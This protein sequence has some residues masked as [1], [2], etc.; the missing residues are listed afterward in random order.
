VSLVE[1]RR[2]GER[3]VEVMREH[4]VVPATAEGPHW[5]LYRTQLRA[6][7]RKNWLFAVRAKGTLV[8]ELGVPLLMLLALILLRNGVE[9]RLVPTV[10]H[11]PLV[12]LD[13]A[14]A[15][16]VWS[17]AALSELHRRPRIGISP[18]EVSYV[19]K[20]KGVLQQSHRTTDLTYVCYSSTAA[21]LQDRRALFAGVAFDEQTVI[22]GSDGS[23]S[24]D[25]DV[26]FV[27][28]MS[29]SLVPY[30]SSSHFQ[31][32]A[33]HSTV[34]ERAWVASGF[35]SVQH[36]V[37]SAITTVRGAPTLQVSMT[38]LPL[39]A[40]VELAGLEYVGFFLPL[41]LVSMHSTAVKAAL[42]AV[43]DEKEQKLREG[44]LMVGLSTHVHMLSWFITLAARQMLLVISCAVLTRFRGIMEHT[45]LSLLFLYFGLFS[46]NCVAYVFLVAA[47]FDSAKVGSVFGYMAF[48]LSAIPFALAGQLPPILT[49]LLCLV[50]PFGFALGA[51]EL[52]RTESLVNPADR[53]LHWG[54]LFHATGEGT[55]TFGYILVAQLVAVV[56]LSF[57]AWYVAEVRGGGSGVGRFFSFCL[58]GRRRGGSRP[59]S[60]RTSPD[61]ERATLLET[62]SPNGI[63]IRNLVKEFALP[64][65]Q[66]LRALDGLSLDLHAGEVTALLGHNGAGKTTTMSILNGLIAPSGGSAHV[67][68]YS[69]QED[70]ARIRQLIGTCPQH[71]VLWPLLTAEEHLDLFAGLKGLV[72]SREEAR[73]ALTAV[74]LADRAEAP[75]GT[76]SG[77]QRRRLSLAIAFL[78]DPKVIMFSIFH[79]CL[80]LTAGIESGGICTFVQLLL[81]CCYTIFV[82]VCII[83]IV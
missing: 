52:W 51:G 79:V 64:S 48:Q 49:H 74:G 19:A 40:F 59:G 6:V 17:L 34:A 20:A 75:A 15:G 16:A 62:K 36:A 7:L 72:L 63:R 56:L 13:M 53:G 27:I 10:Y 67:F 83:M 58:Q 42:G 23:G 24:S 29:G 38:A 46:A 21:M 31:T 68:E 32:A 77:G 78:G 66:V 45:D 2:K 25:G 14:S 44:M 35:L 18:C 60:G 22:G 4:P 73:A 9:E 39:P 70:M 76:L 61:C 69:V 80:I 3:D 81:H 54:T 26:P 11:Q 55:P 28:Y 33:G 50:P 65:G 41:Y 1:M 8:Q 47:F 82:D 30:P 37:Q 71:D 12:N 57:F 5:G 43:L